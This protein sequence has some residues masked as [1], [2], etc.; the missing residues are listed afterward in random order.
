LFGASALIQTYLVNVSKC[1]KNWLYLSAPY[2]QKNT[3]K[4]YKVDLKFVTADFLELKCARISYNK[5]GQNGGKE[6]FG[7]GINQSKPILV[8]K[9]FRIFV[10]LSI[11]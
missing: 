9:R 8:S 3:C 5:I 1:T 4:L 11:F 2:R 10:W 6:T 7:F